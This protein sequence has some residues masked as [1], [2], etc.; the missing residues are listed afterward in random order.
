MWSAAC[1]SGQEPYSMVLTAL[2]HD[3]R[4]AQGNFKLLATDIDPVVVEKARAARYRDQEIEGVPQRF[5]RPSDIQ[6]DPSGIGFTVSD[7]ARALVTF[8]I[9]NLINEPPFAGPFDVIFCR[10]VAIYFDRPTQ[11]QVWG[12]LAARLRRGGLLFI[13]HSERI[14]KSDCPDLDSAGITV[15]RKL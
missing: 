7:E 2:K 6:R 15:Y 14:A 12:R 5:Y 8:G 13:G 9:L 4:V 1:S 10:N 11:Q 3:P